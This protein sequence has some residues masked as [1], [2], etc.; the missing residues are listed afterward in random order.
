MIA[1]AICIVALKPRKF[2]RRNNV[3]IAS[4]HVVRGRDLFVSGFP[5][6]AARADHCPRFIFYSQ[7]YLYLMKKFLFI[8][9]SL[10]CVVSCTDT[11]VKELQLSPSTVNLYYED[12]QQ[13]Q[14]L[15]TS[16]TFEWLTAN[17][18]HATVS[19]NG[20]VTAGHVGSTVITAM[21]GNVKGTCTITVKPKYNLYPTP[22]LVWGA[23]MAQVKNK[24][25][26]PQDQQSN[27]LAYVVNETDGVITMYDFEADKLK[28]VA[29][30]AN[31]KNAD[32]MTKHLVERY[33][34]IG[35]R[36]GTY[37]LI[38]SMDSEKANVAIGYSVNS[39]SS[40]VILMA[41]Y[42]PNNNNSA[43]KAPEHILSNI[44]EDIQLSI[45]EELTQF[46][47]R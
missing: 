35:E 38:D 33:Q 28:S 46:V 29:V 10:V 43:A 42:M 7:L 23:S 17:D 25:G 30:V 5:R 34:P 18:F 6:A 45:P 11:S 47:V 4:A 26:T 36:N 41:I 22:Y 3:Q 12:A 16:G 13:L 39:S 27:A 21:K 37:I 24:L 1:F 44:E 14:V 31:V 8:L 15:N 19:P 2:Q 32:I 40:G 9:L 20:L